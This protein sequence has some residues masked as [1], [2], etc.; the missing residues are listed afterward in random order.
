MTEFAHARAGGWARRAPVVPAWRIALT[1]AVVVSAAVAAVLLD[2]PVGTR[3]LAL[4]V[5]LIGAAVVFGVGVTDLARPHE[6]R[7]AAALIGAGLLWSLAALSVSSD[8]LLYSFGRVSQLLAHLALV[9]LLLSFPTGRLDDRASRL[10]FAGAAALVGLLCLSAALLTGRFATAGLWDACRHGCPRDV[11]ALG[12]ARVPVLAGV[13]GPLAEL[14]AVA[15]LAAIAV[16]VNRRRQR[17]VVGHLYLP[18]AWIAASLA[19]GFAV[20]FPIR[21]IAPSS[22]ALTALGWLAAMSLPAVA[23]ACAAGRLYRRVY[24]ANVLD[25]L[26]RTVGASAAAADVRR[27]LADALGDPS[28]ELLHSF[29]DQQAPWVDEYGSPVERV[30]AGVEQAVTEV[31][32]GGARIA[33]VHDQSL[34]EDLALVRTAGSYA[35]AALGNEHRSDQLRS[36]RLAL[37]RSRARAIAAEDRERRKIERDLHDGAQQRLVAVRMKLGLA[38][39]ELDERDPAGAAVIRTLGQDIDATIDDV[40]AFASAVYPPL[41]AQTGLL[42]ALRS[43]SRVAALPTTVRA[44]RLDRYAPEIETTVYFCCSESLQNAAKHA[45]GATCV[46]IS[47]WEARRRLHFEIGDD[48]AGFDAATTPPGAGLSNLHDR[49]AAVDGTIAIDS[50]PGRGTSV[51]GSIPLG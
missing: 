51:A 4:P 6:P 15:L 44:D 40:R 8:P 43:I 17:A 7:F 48:G 14:L 19:A 12:H 10:L 3:S 9:Y 18:I 5:F 26:A 2:A 21:A 20:F 11:L 46:T 45:R 1:G 47:V 13:I 38:A 32:G 27:A 23:L 22:W 50:T 39:G 24:A 29:P 36:S 16:H 42:Q 49:L 35:L 30:Q 28:L 34:C 31:A 41:L 33:I 37:A 25:R